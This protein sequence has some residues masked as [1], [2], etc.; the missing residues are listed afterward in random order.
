MP[1]LVQWKWVERTKSFLV[2][3]HFYDD[4]SK[5]NLRLKKRIFVGSSKWG[6]ASLPRLPV[7]EYKTAISRESKRMIKFGMFKTE[8]SA[9]TWAP[10]HPELAYLSQILSYTNIIDGL[11]VAEKRELRTKLEVVDRKNGIDGL[12]L[13]EDFFEVEAFFSKDQTGNEREALALI[14][15]KTLAGFDVEKNG[16]T[17]HF[18]CY[19]LCPEY[20]DYLRNVLKPYLRNEKL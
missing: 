17:D 7:P 18:F 2:I 10:S 14:G 3:F 16:Q 15:K 8:K 6:Y 11:D 5:T 19:E 12:I 20:L 9:M 13:P 1:I 4:Y